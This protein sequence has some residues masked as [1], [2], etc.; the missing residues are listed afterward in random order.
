[1]TESIELEGKKYRIVLDN[2][3]KLYA[4]RY[5]KI[6]RHLTGDKLILAM[7]RKIKTLEQTIEDMMEEDYD[8]L[9]WTI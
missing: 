2:E 6:W 5:D 9:H 8:R 4:E 1:M 3:N 7:F